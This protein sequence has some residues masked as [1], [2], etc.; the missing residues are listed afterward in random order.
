MNLQNQFR[1]AKGLLEI[2]K[3]LLKES[4]SFILVPRKESVLSWKI[5]H[6]IM[7]QE[8]E[9]YPGLNGKDLVLYLKGPQVTICTVLEKNGCSINILFR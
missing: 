1:N 6:P 7:A 4:P 5:K 9:F 8:E 2:L 3:F